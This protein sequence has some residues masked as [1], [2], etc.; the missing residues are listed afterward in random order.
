MVSVSSFPIVAGKQSSHRQHILKE[1]W[2]GANKTLFTKTDANLVVSSFY[3]RA[4]RNSHKGGT[5]SILKMARVEEAKGFRYESPMEVFNINPKFVTRAGAANWDFSLFSRYSFSPQQ[6]LHVTRS[7]AS[8][9]QQS[10]LIT[11]MV[12]KILLGQGGKP[13]GVTSTAVTCTNSYLGR[14]ENLLI[15]SLNKL[16]QPNTHSGQSW[17]GSRTKFFGIYVYI[18]RG[19]YVQTKEW[20]K[21]TNNKDKDVSCPRCICLWDF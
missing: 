18:N 3:S 11:Q 14:A 5:R 15:H 9:S 20:N 7:R 1:V 6:Q 19:T 13:A 16:K 17:Q 21:G 2:L 12:V 8:S 10:A 4:M